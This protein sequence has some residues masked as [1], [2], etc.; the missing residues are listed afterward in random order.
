MN[1]ECVER[2]IEHEATSLGGY[3]NWFSVRLRGNPESAMCVG[4]GGQRNSWTREDA[5][6]LLT[7]SVEGW[8]RPG[9]SL[10]MDECFAEDFPPPKKKK[11]LSLSRRTSPLQLIY[12]RNPVQHLLID[13]PNLLKRPF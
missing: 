4:Y 6:S 9:F 2:L 12:S 3:F 5:S 7:S 11:C 10:G 13:L 8:E 1:A